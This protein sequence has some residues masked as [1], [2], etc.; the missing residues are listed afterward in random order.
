MSITLR[1]YRSSDATTIVS[2]IKSEYLM[3]LSERRIGFVMVDGF[4]TW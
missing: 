1:P 2:W 3:R 4:K